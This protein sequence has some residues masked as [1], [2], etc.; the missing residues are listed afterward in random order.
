MLLIGT[1]GPDVRRTGT[2]PNLLLGQTSR[3]V[4][5]RMVGWVCSDSVGGISGGLSSPSHSSGIWLSMGPVVVLRLYSDT[6]WLTLSGLCGPSVRATG[7][8]LPKLVVAVLAIGSSSGSG[9][10]VSQRRLCGHGCR[11]QLRGVL[12]HIGHELFSYVRVR[13]NRHG[14][15]ADHSGGSSRCHGP[16][17]ALATPGS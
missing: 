5:G 8:G 1:F 7:S 11:F 14:T 12:E 9:S 2:H 3:G 17:V 13:Q 10:E 6:V 16:R 4:F 15:R